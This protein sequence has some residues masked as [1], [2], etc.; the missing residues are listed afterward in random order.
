[1]ATTRDFSKYFDKSITVR[2]FI[3]NCGSL[4]RAA[5]ELYDYIIERDSDDFVDGLID[6]TP[7]D[8]DYNDIKDWLEENK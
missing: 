1:M 6:D 3:E 2:E 4:D 8:F 7:E 5:V